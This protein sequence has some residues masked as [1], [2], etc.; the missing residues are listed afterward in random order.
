MKN[1]LILL[2]L[3]ALLGFSLTSARQAPEGV[4]VLHLE[5]PLYVPLARQTR[6]AGDVRVEFRIG[7]TGKVDSAHA[8]SGPPLLAR[9]AER[10]IKTWIFNRGDQDTHEIVYEFQL[11]N[12]EIY[13]DPPSR[14]SFDPP[15]RVRIISNF[16]QV[17]P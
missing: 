3:F 1:V 15:H 13:Y 9:E 12:P 17:N 11:E 5:A 14:V 16:K 10:N 6:I 4:C 8:I 7:P 2:C